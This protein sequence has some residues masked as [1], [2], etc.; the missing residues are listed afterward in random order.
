MRNDLTGREF[1]RLTAQFPVGTNKEGRRIWRCQCKCG[2]LVDVTSCSLRDRT[3][4]SCGCL[5]VDLAR[6]RW[7]RG[8]SEIG[9]GFWNNVVKHAEARDLPFSI[10]IEYAWDLFLP[11][12][13]RCAISGFPLK[14]S[15]A[16]HKK[17][18][19]EQTASLDR[20]DSARGYEI[21]NV[22]WVHKVVNMMKRD[23]PEDEFVTWC[24]RIAD[25]HDMA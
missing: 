8:H 4:R 23:M 20:I 18:R 24:R 10:T 6:K 7:W 22:Q 14:F 11:Q 21:G 13:R 9:L 12:D 16:Y 25:H 2:N 19:A 17:G 5:Q 1:D 15:S 3:T